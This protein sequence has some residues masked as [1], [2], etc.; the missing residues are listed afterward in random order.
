[1]DITETNMDII[2][3]AKR[4]IKKSLTFMNIML[5]AVNTIPVRHS[6]NYALL[7]ERSYENA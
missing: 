1:M 2:T 4:H 3:T 5:P 6:G 7:N